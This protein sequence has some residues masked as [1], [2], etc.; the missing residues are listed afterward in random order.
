LAA[1]YGVI[2]EQRLECLSGVARHEWL[3]KI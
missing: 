1:S 2:I 3:P